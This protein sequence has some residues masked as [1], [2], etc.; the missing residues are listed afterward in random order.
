MTE[1]LQSEQLEVRVKPEGAE[2]TTIEG[3]ANGSDLHPMQQAFMD[4]H[5]LQCGFCTPGMIMV[6][7][8]LL[9]RCP[10]PTERQVREAISGNLCRCTGYRPIVDAALGMHEFGSG[11]QAPS[12]LAQLPGESSD[13]DAQMHAML[14]GLARG[15]S[16]V[17]FAGVTLAGESAALHQ[18]TSLDA[19]LALIARVSLRCGS[20]A[21][22][23]RKLPRRAVAS[24]QRSRQR[25]RLRAT[26]LYKVAKA[27]FAR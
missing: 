10:K 17:A 1:A 21:P 18:P 22:H 11:L 16:S 27:G 20:K 7:E 9:E 6:G 5:G 24:S 26:S 4:N 14:D 25:A 2:L 15:S 3:L 23:T 12:R 13:E 8:E 19:A